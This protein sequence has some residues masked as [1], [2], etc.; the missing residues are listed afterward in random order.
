MRFSIITPTLN[1]SQF[2]EQTIRSVINQ[3]YSDYE[4]IIVDGGS[5]DST[6][7]IL[8]RYKTLKWISEKDN[9][10][11]HAINKGFAMATGDI[12][13]WINSDDYYQE[14]IFESVA[15]YF[16]QHPNCYFLYGDIT[17]VNEH[18]RYLESFKGNNLTLTNLVRCPD[19]I[20]QPSCFWRK[21]VIGQI[22]GLSETLHLVMDFDFLLRI[23]LKF[24]YHYLNKNLSFFRHYQ[25]NK[26]HRL[27][28]KQAIELLT[29]L[30][31]YK[32][33]NIYNVRLILIRYLKSVIKGYIG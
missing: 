31:K 10:Q 13:A 8:K 16:I 15:D 11:S 23:G 4:H 18:G 6:I 25:N 3:N 12:L 30:L 14:N 22:G 19:I 29:V 17:Y 7:D 2:I 20:R 28:K 1:Q 21:D 33:L 9:G 32:K 5:V 26:T 27:L 24:E